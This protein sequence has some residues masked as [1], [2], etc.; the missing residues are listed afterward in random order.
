M[1][2]EIFF[3]KNLLEIGSTEILRYSVN[4]NTQKISL[5]L[6]G[7]ACADPVRGAGGT[8]K[9]TRPLKNHKT[10]GPRMARF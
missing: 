8:G 6:L 4:S 10:I 9:P 2:I 3:K 7:V 5:N 1:R